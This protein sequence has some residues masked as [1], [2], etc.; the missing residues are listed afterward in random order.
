MVSARLRATIGSPAGATVSVNL[1]AADDVGNFL[2]PDL[3][4]GSIAN[5]GQF[6]QMTAIDNTISDVY[7]NMIGPANSHISPSSTG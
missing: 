3:E 2:I 5:V 1:S 6:T 7:L 4:G